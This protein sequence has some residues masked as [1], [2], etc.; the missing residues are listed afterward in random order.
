MK[1]IFSLALM[2]VALLISGQV[3]AVDVASWAELSQAIKDAPAATPTT[4]NVTAGFS[5]S[6]ATNDTIGGGKIITINLGDDPDRVITCTNTYYP[7]VVNNGQLTITGK[8]KIESTYYAVVKLL[9]SNNDVAD[10]STLLVDEDVKL[11]GSQYCV[12]LQQ[13]TKPNGYG[14]VLDVK[15]SLYGEKNAIWLLGNIQQKS[16]NIPIINIYA[17]AVVSSAS[18]NGKDYTAVS[19]MGYGKCNI[20]GKVSG[21]IGVYAKAGEINI[22]GS[23]EI[24]ST[25]TTY[26]AVEPDGDGITG[27]AGN[28]I[29]IDSKE[30]YAGDIV[31]N[32]KDEP[33]ISGA[34]G[35]ALYEVNTDATVNHVDA[36]NISGGNFNGGSAGCLSTTPEVQQEVAQNGTIT[37]GN[38]TGAKTED[39]IKDLL[40]T[41]TGVIV[42]V[43]DELGNTVYVVGEK[44][45]EKSWVSTIGAATTGDYV[46]ID[47]TGSES[48]SGDKVLAYLS[49]SNAY[50]VTVPSGKTL[51]VGE[52]VLNEDAQIVVEAGAKLIV[53]GTNGMVAFNADNL[54]LNA[55]DQN[56]G[57]FL[58]SPNVTAN[59]QPYATVYY[60][61]KYA[62]QTAEDRFKFDRMASITV[63]TPEY[64]TSFKPTTYGGKSW[65]TMFDKWDA[66]TAA[67]VGVTLDSDQN[68]K[69]VPFV[70]YRLAN[71]SA[72]GGAQYEF[73]GQLQGTKSYKM[74]VKTGW[75]YVGNSYTAP[76]DASK[77]ATAL[78]E[79]GIPSINLWDAENQRYIDVNATDIKEGIGGDYNIKSMQTFIFKSTKD[80]E[81]DLDYEET[82]WDY[83]TK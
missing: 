45:A 65:G 14:I 73:K 82:V 9:G 50:T 16:V 46:K 2:A 30:G 80:F 29:I 31:V 51:T 68:P 24:K 74:A 3:K 66:A 25:S 8:G 36:I 13:A 75:N 32:I 40:P 77:L 12:V 63:G 61:A 57:I 41:T 23:A 76:M 60:Y 11:V 48:L 35:Y 52:V 5:S 7:L 78:L 28:A 72:N 79:Q 15:G 27:G 20:E 64:R 1:K 67:W 19:I 83:N 34:A 39:E 53:N 59:M 62:R 58:L 21:A 70:G 22:S 18:T 26:T 43:T 54:V 49:I 56:M 44:P 42:P 17:G 71:R 38:F 10:Y 69:L 81:L 4:I 33:T 37:G 55:D 47:A 6:K